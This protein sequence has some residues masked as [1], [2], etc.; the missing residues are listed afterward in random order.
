[1]SHKVNDRPPEFALEEIEPRI[2]LATCITVEVCTSPI[3]PRLC[4]GVKFCLP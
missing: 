2:E 1:M 3:P 4:F